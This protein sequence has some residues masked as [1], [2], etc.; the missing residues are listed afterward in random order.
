MKALDWQ[1]PGG[2]VPATVSHTGSVVVTLSEPTLWSGS[3]SPNPFTVY[4]AATFNTVN[5]TWTCKSAAGTTLANCYTT[6]MKTASF[7]PSSNFTTGHKYTVQSY[8]GIYDT[9]GNGP[10]FINGTFKAT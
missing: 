8:S 9:S 3:G 2:T 7:K 4:D 10:A 6:P 5:G 1:A